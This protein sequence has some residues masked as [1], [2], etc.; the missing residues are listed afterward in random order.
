MFTIAIHG[1]AGTILPSELT[2]EKEILYRQGLDNAIRAGINILENNGTAMDAV[3]AAV[4]TLENNPLFNA[5]K[6][7]V[8]NHLGRHEMDASIM[9]GKSLAAGAV[10]CVTG[11]KNPVQLARLVM[12]KTEHVMLC[13]SGAEE[14]AH[15]FKLPFESPDYF[16]DS[17]R[18]D[19]WIAIRNS[20]T[21]QLDHSGEKKFGTVGAVACD[22]HGNLAA[23]TSTGGMTNKKY[24]RIGDTPVIGAGT[25]ASDSSCA[26]SCTGHGEFFLKAVVAYDI[27]C[28]MQYKGCS[29]EEACRIVVL[30]KLVKMG[31]E[32][33][34]IAID[35]KGNISLVFNSAGMYRASYK[36][37]ESVQT[38]IYR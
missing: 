10:T 36:A 8:F 3:T 38:S 15:Q 34:V 22:V 21:T 25:Y 5:G 23:A 32:G 9:D 11:V 13:G 27:A 19:Q 33:G 35:T 28:L 37:G 14:L 1:G 29:L 18:H 16:F 6:G 31:G 7:S 24:N 12:E 20:E 30:D 2:A 26:V 17:F 4:T